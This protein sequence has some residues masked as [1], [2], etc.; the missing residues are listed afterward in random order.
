MLI[1]SNIV[2]NKIC[3][4]CKTCNMENKIWVKK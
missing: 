3:K 2:N 1:I 4:Y